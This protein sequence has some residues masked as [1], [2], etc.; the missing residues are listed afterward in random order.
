M[1]SLDTMLAR[2]IEEANNKAIEILSEATI[3]KSKIMEKAEQKLKK[4]EES[5][6]SKYEQK[7]SSLKESLKSSK[8]LEKR[9]ILLKAK[10]E[11]I[12]FVLLEVEKQLDRLDIVAYI[13]KIMSN[14]KLD[15]GEKLLVSSKYHDI[16]I[17]YPFDYTDSIDCGFL[18]TKNNITENYNPKLKIKY[19]IDRIEKIILEHIE[20][21]NYEKSI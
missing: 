15:K 12:K 14:R 9:D 17:E 21:S 16:K 19:E 11:A 5:L 1:K 6:I 8:V 10:Q 18:I 20:K 3:E 7:I 13:N 2:I 4:D